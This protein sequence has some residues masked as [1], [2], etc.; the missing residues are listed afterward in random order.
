MDNDWFTFDT[1]GTLLV[2][3]DGGPSRSPTRQGDSGHPQQHDPIIAQLQQLDADEVGKAVTTAI[4]V[5][6]LATVGKIT[7]LRPLF[8]LL[9]YLQISSYF[10]SKYLS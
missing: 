1:V 2:G 7:I 4:E 9:F 5:A 8:Y 6:A 10:L 3:W